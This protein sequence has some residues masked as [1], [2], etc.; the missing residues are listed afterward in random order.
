MRRIQSIYK[1]SILFAML[2]TLAVS[3]NEDIDKQAYVMEG[4]DTGGVL[5]N[6]TFLAG[7][8]FDFGD[9]SNTYLSFIADA[10]IAG[11]RTFERLV[12]SKSYNGG[13]TI[14]HQQLTPS[15]MPFQ[16]DI[17]PEDA[18]DGF[19]ISTAEIAGGDYIDW[20][21]MIEF[22]DPDV[23]FNDDALTQ[24]FPDFRS[25]FVCAFDENV[26]VG[27]YQITFSSWEEDFNIV[28][29]TFEVVAGPGE[30]QVTLV[31]P[32]GHGAID[33]NNYDLVVDIDP[34]SGAAV[35]ATQI[36]WDSD[37]YGW[38]YGAITADGAGYV[39][40]CAGTISL[41]LTYCVPSLGAGVC[42]SAGDHIEAV[43]Q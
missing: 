15:E 42:F 16:V 13:D 12:I 20:M 18:V 2:F 29:T 40:S 10:A 24:Q 28:G 1:T 39:L 32:L 22:A 38:G 27:T 34:V 21:F 35:V 41:D 11:N 23:K 37:N 19:G 25:Y 9:M 6:V 36:A 30:N 7:K 4:T 17:T 3:C 14:I 31:D 5:P 8:N 26:T 43:K 33:G